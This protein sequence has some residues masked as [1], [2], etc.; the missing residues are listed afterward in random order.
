MAY[1]IVWKLNTPYEAKLEPW[2]Y[3]TNYLDKINAVTSTGPQRCTAVLSDVG[4]TFKCTHD[5]FADHVEVC[6]TEV[7]FC[8][9]SGAVDL[10]VLRVTRIGI[11]VIPNRV[12]YLV[13]MC[14][15]DISYSLY[16]SNTADEAS[17][18]LFLK[19]IKYVSIITW[20]CL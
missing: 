10:N 8:F 7:F 6:I 16:F 11:S 19:K 13:L 17:L 20:I 14:W 5:I 12:N 15:S 1:S 18:P 4:R 9:P 3:A 2:C